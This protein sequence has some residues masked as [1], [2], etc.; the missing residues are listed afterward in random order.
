MTIDRILIAYMTVAGIAVGAIVTFM[1]EVREFRV[2]PYFWVLI[3]IALFDL[4]A[5]ARGRG[6]PG[7]MVTMDARLLGFVMAIVL[8][9]TIPVLFG[10]PL[11][12]LF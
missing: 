6:A 2:S 8:M 3:A 1:P 5:F 4:V 7:T 10:A 11:P 9:V 12:G